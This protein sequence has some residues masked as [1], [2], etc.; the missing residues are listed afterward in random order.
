MVVN[1]SCTNVSM[2]AFP[3]S[4][5]GTNYYSMF[6]HINPCGNGEGIY[7]TNEFKVSIINC[8]VPPLNSYNVK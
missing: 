7:L 4:T 5:K 3:T 8:V 6:C 2:S 1:G